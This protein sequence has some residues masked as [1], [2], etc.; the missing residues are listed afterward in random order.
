MV[1]YL[2]KKHFFSLTFPIFLSL[3]FLSCSSERPAGKTE[4]EVLYQE[5]Q[6][7][8]DEGRYL[9]ATEK[10]NLIRSRYPYSFYATHAELMAADVLFYQEN[11]S[12]AAAAYIVFRD[13]HPK[14][15]KGSYVLF[16]IAES[17]YNQL[18]ST[19]D[20]DL[21]PGFEARRYYK[22]LTRIYPKS[23]YVKDTNIKIKVIDEMIQNKEKYVADFYF[24]TD[25]FGSAR[26]RYMNILKHFSDIDLRDHS[27]V[28]V[29]KSSAKLSD[30]EV[31]K[32]YYPQY[33]KEISNSRKEEL[34]SAFERCLNS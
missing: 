12:E 5:A 14:Y 21:S 13:L 24:K 22:E 26:Y 7:L 32:K 17:F 2:L 23:K 4:A 33:L 18:P 25:V 27:M 29:I 31:C 19:F 8:V 3:I 34:K 6:V 16:K 10:L 30:K 20:R 1:E 28:R 9:L 15:E 11:F